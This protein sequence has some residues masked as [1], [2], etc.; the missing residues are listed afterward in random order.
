[1]QLL[2]AFNLQLDFGKHLQKPQVNI[3]WRNLKPTKISLHRMWLS[4]SD[5]NRQLFYG[6]FLQKFDCCFENGVT[7]NLFSKTCHHSL[8]IFRKCSR[9]RTKNVAGVNKEAS[10]SLLKHKDIGQY[11]IRRCNVEN[12]RFRLLPT[13]MF[14]YRCMIILLFKR[15]L[16]MPS[17]LQIPGGPKSSFWRQHQ[18]FD[19]LCQFSNLFLAGDWRMKVSFWVTRFGS[20]LKKGT[21]D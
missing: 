8:K 9:V 10:E 20:I 21:D 15:K 18:N 7:C 4:S 12:K 3:Y 16:L 13:R 19:Y 14:S 6:M 2:L 17:F 1:M 5:F 11:R